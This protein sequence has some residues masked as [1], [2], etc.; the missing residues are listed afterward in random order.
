MFFI[1]GHVGIAIATSLAAWTYAVLLG[2]TLVRLGHFEPDTA[3]K[4]RGVLITVASGAM[5]LALWDASVPLEQ[6]FAPGN[7]IVVQL[8]ALGA[9]IAG[10][11]MVYLAMAQETGAA[12]YRALWRSMAQG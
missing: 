1:L 2:V 8:L 10:G 5:A 3:L 7:G 12:N 11:G 6:Y 4:R 9:L